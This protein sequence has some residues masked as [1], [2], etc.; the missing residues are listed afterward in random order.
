MADQRR[1]F[2]WTMY[3]VASLLV[4]ALGAVVVG[5][6]WLLHGRSGAA[7]GFWF[8]VLV[9]M[10]VYLVLG[11]LVVLFVV[12]WSIRTIIRPLGNT[13]VVAGRVAQGDLT[14][15]LSTVG[16]GQAEVLTRSIGTMVGEL[17]GLVAAIRGS[18]QEAAAMAQQI[19]SSTQEM[20]ASTEEVSG[21]CNDLTDRATKQAALVRQAAADADRILQIAQTLDQSSSEAAE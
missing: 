5:V 21:T 20:S 13:V 19:S 3:L 2:V 18:A 11:G 1:K 16:G 4:V 17:R 12:S 8:A 14:V 9:A 15:S 7:P 10:A 6:L